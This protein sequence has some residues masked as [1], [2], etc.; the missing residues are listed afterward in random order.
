MI[1]AVIVED[2]VLARIGLRQAIPWEEMGINLLDDAQDGEEALKSIEQFHPQII[3]LDL[4]IP[5]VSGM[6]IL[7]WLKEHENPAKVIV[8]TAYED[9]KTVKTALKNGAFDYLRKLNMDIEELKETLHKCINEINQ[10]TDSRKYVKKEIR[11][12]R[13][14]LD[15]SFGK[16]LGDVSIKTTVIVL[17]QNSEI[18]H[19]LFFEKCD[20][21][22]REKYFN[23]IR[24]IKNEEISY[25]LFQEKPGYLFYK[26]EE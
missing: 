24:L 15:K 6:E 22:I 9:F 18:D 23:M 20:G 21:F 25:Y 1:N 3:F 19:N 2:E 11:Y 5:K 26:E 14:L 4:N 17:L 7:A 12:T 13:L 8:I 16:I 10:D